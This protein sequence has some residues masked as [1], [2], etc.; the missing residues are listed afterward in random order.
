[1]ICS[2]LVNLEVNKWT[3]KTVLLLLSLIHA[4]YVYYVI[5]C[6]SCKFIHTH[7]SPY[8]LIP[9]MYHTAHFWISVYIIMV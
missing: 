6:N 9:A 5:L 1:M 3:T 4:T 7:L 2:G 8:T